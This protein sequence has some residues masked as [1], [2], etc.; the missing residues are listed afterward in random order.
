MR[1]WK[2]FVPPELTNLCHSTLIVLCF[3]LLGRPCI[4][5]AA[6]FLPQTTSYFPKPQCRVVSS[7]REYRH[8][9]TS[10]TSLKASSPSDDVLSFFQLSEA[11]GVDCSALTGLPYRCVPIPPR[12]ASRFPSVASAL[13]SNDTSGVLSVRA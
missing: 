12:Q 11:N 4:I 10:A 5:L 6:T 3:S 9:L 13:D 1:N 8:A 7:C 2:P